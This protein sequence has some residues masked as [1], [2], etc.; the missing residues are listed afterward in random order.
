MM[1]H[2]ENC[3]MFLA[4]WLDR[5]LELNL[6]LILL[7]WPLEEIRFHQGPIIRGIYQ[8][9]V[10]NHFHFDDLQSDKVLHLKHRQVKKLGK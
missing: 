1:Y 10:L 3:N 8:W 6:N 5:L 9:K 2:I 7:R 4:D